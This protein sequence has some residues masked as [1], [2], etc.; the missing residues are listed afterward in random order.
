MEGW[1]GFEMGLLLKT[2]FIV[3]VRRALLRCVWAAGGPEERWGGE[4]GG[5]QWRGAAVSVVVCSP[6]C[7]LRWGNNKLYH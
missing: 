4:G 7:A 1:I 2:D 5:A 6:T 3:G